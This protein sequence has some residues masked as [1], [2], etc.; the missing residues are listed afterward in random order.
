MSGYE[1]GFRRNNN[2]DKE[3]QNAELGEASVRPQ[4]SQNIHATPVWLIV[5]GLKAGKHTRNDTS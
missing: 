5:P 4:A 3:T 1:K 2:R